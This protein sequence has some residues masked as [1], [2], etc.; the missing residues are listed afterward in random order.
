M[1]F[2]IKLIYFSIILIFKVTLVQMYLDQINLIN[3]YYKKNF[4]LLI[5][6]YVN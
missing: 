2:D 1:I 6:I 3:K 4:F 5:E